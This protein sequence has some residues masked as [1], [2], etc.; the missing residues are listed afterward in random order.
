MPSPNLVSLAVGISVLLIIAIICS[1]VGVFPR[2]IKRIENND[3]NDQISFFI[4]EICDNA[5][6]EIFA[7]GGECN[8][9]FWNKQL[10]IDALN[11]LI[12]N[13][14]KINICS[15]PWFDVQSV[16]L[17]KLINDGKVNYY[18]ANERE[19]IIH[20]W[21]NDV[22]AVACHPG[23]EQN[24]EVGLSGSRYINRS[25]K[26]EFIKKSAGISPIEQGKFIEK[27]KIKDFTLRE[28]HKSQYWFTNTTRVE[29]A[30][31][32]EIA[33]LIKLLQ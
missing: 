5:M 21:G 6:H 33:S 16:W 2:K 29:P 14:K 15:G 22:D 26:K 28:K 3:V 13:N 1:K 27:F 4:N 32:H 12:D 30:N 17:A 24:K 25:F 31:E 7:V 8:H 10:I 23:N 20:F 19:D 18:M 9:N 11:N